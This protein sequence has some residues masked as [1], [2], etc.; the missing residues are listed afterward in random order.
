M[1]GW[2]ILGLA[3][4]LWCV[5]AVPAALLFGRAIR[6][7]EQQDRGHRHTDPHA[8]YWGR[9]IPTPAPGRRGRHT[10]A[11]ARRSPSWARTDRH[12]DPR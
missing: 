6:H 2:Q 4:A 9:D 3:V 1:N 12:G 10:A 7:G 11:H 8:A 5:A